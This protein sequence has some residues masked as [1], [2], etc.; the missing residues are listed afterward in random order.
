MKKYSLNG[1]D[2]VVYD[3]GKFVIDNDGFFEDYTP[4]TYYER[5]RANFNICVDGHG[6]WRQPQ[7]TENGI[8]FKGAEQCGNSLR[9]K[10]FCGE[11][12]NIVVRLENVAG[13][14]V[15]QNTV[16]NT[17]N[18][19]TNL[20]SLSSA[21]VEYIGHSPNAPWYEK[22]IKINLCHSKWQGRVSGVHMNRQI[23]DCI[24]QQAVTV[25]VC[26]TVLVQPAVGVLM[27]FTPSSLLRTKQ[28][29]KCGLWKPRVRIADR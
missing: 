7:L 27:N 14:I 4:S 18:E 10:Y 6:D 29:E 12:I 1:I 2:I 23:L 15:Q 13:V 28:M 21:F 3:S 8:V 16:T 20:T 26:F 25:R 19:K 17:S 22:D 9:L 11:G 5:T 24:R